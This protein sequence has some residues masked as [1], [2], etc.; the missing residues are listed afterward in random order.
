MVG[1][2]DDVIKR[3]MTEVQFYKYEAK[4]QTATCLLAA[5]EAVSAKPPSTVA[6][7]A[8]CAKTLRCNAKTGWSRVL[9]LDGVVV[10]MLFAAVD[11]GLLRIDQLAVHPDHQGKGYGRALLDDAVGFAIQ[12]GLTSVWL[13]V[14]DFN[15]RAKAFYVKYGFTVVETVRVLDSHMADVVEYKV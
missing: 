3:T 2:S 11:S 6:Y 13:Y 4:A 15:T 8:K 9:R 5:W 12:S 1:S 10:A 14:D 7:I